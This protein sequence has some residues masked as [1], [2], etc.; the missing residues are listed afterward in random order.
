MTTDGWLTLLVLVATLG[1][2]AWNRMPPPAV[3]LSATIAL[4][5]TEVIDSSQAFSGFSNPA[6]ITVAALYVLA[7][8]AQKTGLLVPVTSRLLGSGKTRGTLARLLLPAA[9]ASAFLNNTPLVA[10]LMP[11]VI[12]WARRHG[13]SASR[14]LLP[15]SYAAILGGTLT[16]L[17]TST[18][19]VVSGLLQERG[20][21]PFGL[22]EI[23]RI[24]GPVVVVG[25]ALLLVTAKLLPERRSVAEQA[26]A[27]VREFTVDM[28]VVSAG[29]VDGST[30]TGAGLRDLNGVY[31]VQIDRAGRI[32]TPV[33]PE[34]VLRGGDRLTFAGDVSQVVDLQRMRGLRSA[35]EEHLLE[36][37]GPGHTF[38]EAVIGRSSPLSGRT[39]KEVDFR[40]R[41][42]AAVVAIHRDGH[43]VAE[44]LGQI[45]LR[46]GDTMLLVADLRFERQWR[47][48]HDFLLATRLGGP[49]PSATRKAPLVGVIAVAMILLAAF[50]IL[51][52]LEGALLAAGLL[53]ITQT[54]S[55]AEARDAIDL[56]VIVLI[57]AAFGLGAAVDSTGLAGQVASGFV[58]ALDMFGRAGIVLGVVAATLLLTEVVTN[59]AAAVVVLPIAL[60]IAATAGIDPRSMAMAVAVAASASFLTPIGYQTNTM[61]Y[62]PG[63]YRFTDYLRVGAPMTLAVLVTITTVVVTTG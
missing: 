58:S 61:V 47:H 37:D 15:L 28:S 8:A 11:D 59:N 10:I 39:L 32:I 38:F 9:G 5:V 43:R 54:L 26:A 24:G 16:L 50:N 20:Q 51:P 48:S 53:V 22:F 27:E 33:N 60:N 18:N 29:P 57:G 2:L 56:N 44:K 14:F 55:M 12:G 36:V 45:Q 52:I 6:P 23:T 1:L 19:L 63:G 41:H 30:V 35:E 31:L 13:L 42:A 7:A 40:R 25:L 34:E 46:P 62:G 49:P 21:E 3:V 4:L 17:G